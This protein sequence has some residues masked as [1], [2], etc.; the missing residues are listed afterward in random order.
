[1]AFI[2]SPINPTKDKDL[3]LSSKLIS[4]A[5]NFV[6]GVGLCTYIGYL[7]DESTGKKNFYLPIGAGV[8]LVWAFYE[9]FKLVFWLNKMNKTDNLE[10]NNLKK[11]E[12][13]K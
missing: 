4:V 6:A 5:S 10:K 2:K 13:L 9:T 7:I 8:G 1:M 11:T 3:K 12:T